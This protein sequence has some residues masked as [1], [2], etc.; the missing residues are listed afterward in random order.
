M[1]TPQD[2]PVPPL[3]PAATRLNDTLQ[4][5][6]PGSGTLSRTALTEAFASA[7]PGLSHSGKSRQSLATLLIELADAQL[8]TLPSN[9][10]KWD[11]GRPPLPDAVRIVRHH[12][13]PSAT[14]E[15]RSWRPE[16]SWVSTARVT[17][18]Q[19]NILTAI[20]RWF[21]DTSNTAQARRPLSLRE[22]SHEIFNDEKRLDS[23]IGGALFGPGRLDLDQ[24]ATYREAPPLAYRHLGDGD[25]ILV[26]EN[27]DTFATLRHLL[28]R[29]PGRIGYIA[30]GAGRAFE[31]TVASITELRQIR[32]ILY[33]GDL[34]ADGL[35]IPARASITATLLGLPPVEP[36]EG[37]YKLL[38]TRPRNTALKVDPSHARLLVEW[39]PPA[40]QDQALA[41]LTAGD[42]VAQ[43][44]A[45]QN[46]HLEDT[47]WLTIRETARMASRPHSDPL[48][49]GAD[50]NGA[51]V[52][53]PQ[54]AQPCPPAKIREP[55]APS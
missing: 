39:L 21:R 50:G 24:L 52:P 31:A 38:L 8:L 5:R 51:S 14:R 54:A 1:T 48:P 6:T 40:L 46:H 7:L 23:L 47:Q 49:R 9:P 4:A 22:R 36:A 10:A 43:E 12:P 55:H 3:S 53:A 19:T 35:S 18:T 42:R 20:N 16:L 17:T 34:D 26:I 45:N 44:A 11:A 15:A 33:Y 41:M 2:G 30:F 29:E 32:R 37:C 25:T 13:V 28:Q 27:S